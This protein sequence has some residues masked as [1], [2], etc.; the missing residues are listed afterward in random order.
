M[1]LVPVQ[2]FKY[3]YYTMHLKY[4]TKWFI[5]GNF[6]FSCMSNELP[7]KVCA[8]EGSDKTRRDFYPR[9]FA[10]ARKTPAIIDR[11]SI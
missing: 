8:R 1:F 11:D 9:K 2:L 4:G 10:V 7:W 5:G 6:F 3:T